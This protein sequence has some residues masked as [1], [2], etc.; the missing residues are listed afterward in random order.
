MCFCACVLLDNKPLNGQEMSSS[1]A[2]RFNRV[3]ESVND[4]FLC[5]CALQHFM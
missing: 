2:I 4:C 5:V 3:G 1:V